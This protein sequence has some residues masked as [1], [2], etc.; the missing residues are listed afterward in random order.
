MINKK[1]LVI[2]ILTFITISVWVILDIIHARANVEIPAETKDVLEPI[3]PD[4]NTQI[5][6]SMP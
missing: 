1:W 5:L 4:F 3:S 2:A 6:K